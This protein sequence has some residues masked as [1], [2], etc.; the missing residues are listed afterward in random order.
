ME[1]KATEVALT[2]KAAPPISSVWHATCTINKKRAFLSNMWRPAI[3]CLFRMCQKHLSPEMQMQTETYSA[4][5]LKF[6]L[7]VQPLGLCSPL[8]GMP[9]GDKLLRTQ[10][11]PHLTALYGNHFLRAGGEREDHKQTWYISSTSCSKVSS[12]SKALNEGGKLEGW[13]YNFRRPSCPS[14]CTCV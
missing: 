7:L 13:R 14:F 3:A 2:L 10:H 8:D 6:L 4:D 11:L 1:Q 9:T 5:P 12:C